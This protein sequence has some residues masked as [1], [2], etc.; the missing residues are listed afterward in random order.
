M[1]P[2]RGVAAHIFQAGP[3]AAERIIMC[4]CDLKVTAATEVG[5]LIQVPPQCCQSE[6][7]CPKQLSGTLLEG[8]VVERELPFYLCHLLAR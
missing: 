8:E 7:P 1:D 4:P 6:L 5:M 2:G 3:M